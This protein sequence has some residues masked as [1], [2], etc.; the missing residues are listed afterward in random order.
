MLSLARPDNRRNLACVGLLVWAENR[1]FRNL[2]GRHRL[3]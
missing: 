2:I 1:R 3:T